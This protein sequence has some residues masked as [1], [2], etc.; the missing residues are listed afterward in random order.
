MTMS[1]FKPVRALTLCLSF[2]ASI[3]AFAADFNP[4]SA[5]SYD[6]HDYQLAFQQVT[7]DG[8]A[9]LFEYTTGGETVDNWTRLVTINYHKGIKV[10]PYQWGV[11]MQRRLDSRAPVPHYNVSMQGTIGY[12]QII[13]VPDATNTMYEANVHKAFTQDACDGV[14]ALQYAMKYPQGADTSAAGV[15]QTLTGIVANSKK[16][17]A[18]ITDYSWSPTCK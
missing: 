18:Y 13:F 11:A 6:G 9:G 10:T 17:L 3:S 2:C 16:D 15:R 8:R 4:P 14:V 1:Y 5:L 7:E 12:A